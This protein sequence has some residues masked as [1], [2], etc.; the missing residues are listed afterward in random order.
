MASNRVRVGK[1]KGSDPELAQLLKLVLAKLG[2]GDSDVGDAP[3]EGEDC[4]EGPSRP[5]H[6][7]VTQRVAFP[8]VKRRNKKQV[9]AVQQPMPSQPVTPP[10]MVGSVTVGAPVP[11]TAS[12]SENNP[13]PRSGGLTATPGP[14]LGVESMLADIRRSLAVLA[15][16]PK[17]LPVQTYPN[18]QVVAPAVGATSEQGL[19]ALALP[20]AS[21][22]P[23]TQPAPG[24]LSQTTLVEREQGKVTEQGASAIKTLAS[25]EGT[26]L[27]TLLP[28][29]GKLA[30]HVA[31]DINEKIWKGEFVDIFSLMRAKRRD[32]ET[33][34]KDSKASS[35]SD[36]KPKIEESI[37]NW[38]FGFNVFMS[39]MLEKIPETGIVPK[40][41]PGQFRLIH[42]LSAPRGASV[43]KAID[44]VLC[45]V[46]YATVDQA[47]EKLKVLGRGMLLAKTD[48]EAA[49]RLLPVHPED[50]HLLGFQ[51]NGDYS[52]DKCMPMGCSV[53]CSYFEQFSSA[54]QWI[55]T[56]RTGHVN[57]IHYLDDFLVLGPLSLKNASGP[58]RP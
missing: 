38:L 29:P 42:N 21:Q 27:D 43:N 17:E 16:L 23:K 56:R 13:A 52:F 57:V 4:G 18:P 51:F 50:Y 25:A 22:D 41:D 37:T 44:P 33:K 45:S 15:A 34:D 40:K 26:G 53:S 24:S 2:D 39:V 3:S 58:C 30:A 32:V 55:F 6:T 5:R 54:L 31:P 14:T 8:P 20:G 1:R 49:F 10:P 47:L 36:K 19:V 28:R 7:H 12:P 35:S 11:A 9:T 48:I 46:R